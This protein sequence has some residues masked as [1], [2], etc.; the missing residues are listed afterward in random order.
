MYVC[1][2]LGARDTKSKKQG[3]FFG[4]LSLVQEGNKVRKHLQKHSNECFE[5]FPRTMWKNLE[6]EG[7]SW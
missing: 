2:K 5:R 6:G 1:I 7:D 3:I 4:V